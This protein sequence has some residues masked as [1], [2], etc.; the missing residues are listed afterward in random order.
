MRITCLIIATFLVGCSSDTPDRTPD[1]M[2]QFGEEES[3]DCQA[4]SATPVADDDMVDVGYAD[5]LEQVDVAALLAL[6][7]GSFEETLDWSDGTDAEVVALFVSAADPELVVTEDSGESPES[8]GPCPTVLEFSVTVA[9]STS[10]GRVDETF[11]AVATTLGEQIHVEHRIPDPQGTVDTQALA[12]PGVQVEPDE[13]RVN[14]RIAA[15]SF[16][17]QVLP[18]PIGGIDDDATPLGGWPQGLF[19]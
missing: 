1:R 9:L 17:G 11:D 8:G 4:V 14:V 5:S 16:F 7:S 19:E 6:A 15:D 12:A 10:D 2:G 3:I 13:I 18:Q